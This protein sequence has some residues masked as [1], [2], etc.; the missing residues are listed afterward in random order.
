WAALVG[1]LVWKPYLAQAPDTWPSLV[2]S[3]SE[4]SLF[5]AAAWGLLVLVP[6]IEVLIVFLPVLISLRQGAVRQYE[7]RAEEVRE[8]HTAPRMRAV[9]AGPPADDMETELRTP[10]VTG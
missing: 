5:P 2:A 1:P 7:R 6:M 4:V 3:V 9:G 10:P 8:A